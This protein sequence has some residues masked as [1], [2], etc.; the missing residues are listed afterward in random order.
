MSLIRRENTQKEWGGKIAA[1]LFLAGA[2]AGAYL[3]AFIAVLVRPGLSSLVVTAVL[4]SFF[5]LIAGTAFLVFDL[6]KKSLAFLAFSRPSR[7][8]I[9]RGTIIITAFLLLDFVYIVTGVWPAAGHDLASVPLLV[10]GS[11]TAAAALLVLTYTGMVLGAARPVEFWNPGFLVVLFLV[12]G[13]SSGIA[14]TVLCLS[15]YGLFPGRETENTLEFLAACGAAALALEA[16]VLGLYLFSMSRR[17]PSSA[18][19]LIVTGG[20]LSRM[21]WG[22][23]VASL[24][25]NLA[26]DCCVACSYSA[27]ALH[28]P[29]PAIAV[30]LL[31][32]L[33]GFMLRY[34]IVAG[35]VAAPVNIGGR[36]VPA[37]RVTIS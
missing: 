29:V 4:L 31:G 3:V 11:L 13:I 32:L 12:S 5:L 17:A 7:S 28:L 10:L 33:S 6:G 19:V 23:V 35:G 37:P 26:F 2:G 27:S 18:S 30:S 24:L 1:Y 14:G 9:S 21:F 16:A 8:W 15:V 20:S 22:A 25:I 36:L 34:I